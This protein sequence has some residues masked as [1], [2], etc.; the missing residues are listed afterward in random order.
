MFDD[1]FV[2]AVLIDP[3]DR[4]ILL[5]DVQFGVALSLFE[6]RVIELFDNNMTVFFHEVVQTARN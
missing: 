1:I 2:F 4:Q 6:L 3:L 5:F